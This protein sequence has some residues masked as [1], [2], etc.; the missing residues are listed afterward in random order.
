MDMG[1]IYT[2]KS[3][4]GRFPMQSLISDVEEADALARSVWVLDAVNWIGLA[5]KKIKAET[6]EKSFAEAGF[7]ESDVADNLEEANENKLLQYLISSEE[8]K[9]PM[10]QRT[11]FRVMTI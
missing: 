3:H 11:V 8:K 2:F 9:F 1:V 7:V 6:V 4:Y 10:I 5:A